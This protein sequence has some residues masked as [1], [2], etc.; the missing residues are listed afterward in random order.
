M[1][2]T[3][4]LT[5]HVY[6]AGYDLSGDVA[7]LTAANK[8]VAAIEATG[9]DVSAI[10]RIHGLQSGEL[11]VNTYLNP[12]TAHLHPVLKVIP[13]ADRQVLYFRGTLLGNPV[14]CL[15]GKQLTYNT[16]RAADGALTGTVQVKS[17]G[18]AKGLEWGVS[19]TPGKVVSEAEEDLDGVD[20]GV[21]TDGDLSVYLQ[22]F[23]F[24]GTNVTFVLEDSD[25]DGDL[26][27]Y[28]AVGAFALVTSAP[29]VQH[30]IVAG[31]IKRWLRVSVTSA[32]GFTSVTYAIAVV[33]YGPVTP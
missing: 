30:I 15:L 26:D 1:G 25:D 9:L 7:A 14:A 33:R 4:G 8:E 23:A 2:K 24:A 21:G 6:V 12:A 10:E 17:S 3:T 32:G 19:L 31:P 29:G 18:A 11:S 5:D 13:A 20:N 22:V 16:A 27:P 28:S